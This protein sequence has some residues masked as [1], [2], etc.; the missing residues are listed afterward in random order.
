MRRVLPLLAAVLMMFGLAACATAR[1]PQSEYDREFQRYH[2]F[3]YNID[4]G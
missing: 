4:N 1:K 2:S 3:P